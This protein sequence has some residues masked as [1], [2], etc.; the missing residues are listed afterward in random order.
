MVARREG[1]WG[2]YEKDEVINKYKLLVTKTHRD[3]K[4]STGNTV[5]DIAITMHSARWVV[6]ILRGTLCKIYNC[7]TTMPYTWKQYKIIL[8]VNCNWK[9]KKINYYTQKR[10]VV[11]IYVFCAIVHRILYFS[12]ISFK[13]LLLLYREV[14]SFCMFIL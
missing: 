11:G 3:V 8:K 5:N 1:C 4:Y 13:W 12:I 6:Q 9:L 14:I 2:L 10:L 7:L